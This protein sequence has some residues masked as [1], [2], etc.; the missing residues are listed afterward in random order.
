MHTANVIDLVKYQSVNSRIKSTSCYK[1]LAILAVN[2]KRSVKANKV[3]SDF[4]KLAAKATLKSNEQRIREK[5]PEPIN[6]TLLEAIAF[7]TFIEAAA[8]ANKAPNPRVIHF[9][10]NKLGYA[11]TFARQVTKEVA[12]DR[13]LKLHAKG[14]DRITAEYF[15]FHYAEHLVTPEVYGN[16]KALFQPKP[17]ILFPSNAALA[18]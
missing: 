5:C 1:K 3:H 9:Q 11:G 10:L 8:I 18:A 2:I 12:S 7:K 14:L 15:I 4:H 17:Q 6:N 16:V 13:F